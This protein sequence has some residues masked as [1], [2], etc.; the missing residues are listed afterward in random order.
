M[1]TPE[2]KLHLQAQYVTDRSWFMIFGIAL[3]FG[4]VWTMV[5]DSAM[6]VVFITAAF[7]LFLN[8]M[9]N[10]EMTTRALNA[11]DGH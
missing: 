4:F 10:M 2:E 3:I 5:G 7:I 1:S 6:R 8:S 9:I 11:G